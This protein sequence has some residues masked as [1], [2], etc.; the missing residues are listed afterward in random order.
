VAHRLCGPA[1]LVLCFEAQGDAHVV[2]RALRKTSH[3]LLALSRLVKDK[4]AGVAPVTYYA[5]D[6]EERELQRT[7]GEIS[8]SDVGKTLQGKVNTRGLCATYEQGLKFA[9]SGGLTQNTAGRLT[10]AAVGPFKIDARDPSPMSGS[11]ASDSSEAATSPPS[12]PDDIAPPIHLMFLGSTLGN[13]SRA[14]GAD[15]L[16]SLPLRSGSGDTL[17]IGMD[18]DNEKA[19][20]EEAYND[21]QGYTKKFIM[22]GLKGAGRALGDEN[23]FDE[24]NWDYV[25]VN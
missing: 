12:T 24:E 23:L 21:R 3:I 13:F 9:E 8:L 7:L 15:F 22:N 4:H 11:S 19:L 18:H 25:N 10:R 17:L 5:L 16:R 6:L 14:E 1:I 20:I 2:P